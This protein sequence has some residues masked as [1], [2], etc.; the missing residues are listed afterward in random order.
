MNVTGCRPIAAPPLAVALPRST[1][2]VAAV[3]KTCHALGVPCGAARGGNLA[4]RGGPCRRRI[5]WFWAWR[6]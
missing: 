3:L 4:C 1:E 6:G 2:E 5:V